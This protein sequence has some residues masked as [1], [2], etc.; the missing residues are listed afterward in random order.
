MWLK[1][2][3]E[4]AS[5]QLSSISAAE[6]GSQAV[7]LVHEEDAALVAQ[8]V[9]EDA[10]HGQQGGVGLQDAGAGRCLAQDQG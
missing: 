9:Q 6:K 10:F 5:S 8:G 2:K 4:W 7:A 1:T 3:G